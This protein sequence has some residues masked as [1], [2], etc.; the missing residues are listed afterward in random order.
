MQ[1]NSGHTKSQ[2]I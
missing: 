1:C 2:V